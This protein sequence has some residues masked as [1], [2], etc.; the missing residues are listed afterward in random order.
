MGTSPLHFP[1][2]GGLPTAVPLPPTPALLERTQP[3]GQVSDVFLFINLEHRQ[4][5]QILQNRRIGPGRHILRS[6]PE[7]IHHQPHQRQP[8]GPDALHRQE[9]MVQRPQS[10]PANHNDGQPQFHRPFPHRHVPRDRHQPT[11]HRF[12]QEWTRMSFRQSF[13]RFPHGGEIKRPILDDARRI[14]RQG[15]LPRHRIDFVERK[16]FPVGRRQHF[17]IRAFAAENGLQPQCGNTRPP[18][19]PRQRRSEP[20]FAHSRIRARNKQSVH[21]SS[22]LSVNPP[23]IN[24]DA[25]DSK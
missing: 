8:C 24:P 14:G 1:C 11:S 5:R 12:D 13:Q 3:R 6:H 19:C 25:P 22:T 16:R 20:G 10:R 4:P 2:S 23:G 7:K 21:C 18:K 9:R 15:R 17:R